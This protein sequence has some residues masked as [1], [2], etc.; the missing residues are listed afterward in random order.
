MKSYSTLYHERLAD[1][2]LHLTPD[3]EVDIKKPW[4][5]NDPEH[6]RRWVLTMANRNGINKKIFTSVLNDSHVKVRRV[7]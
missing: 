7:A 2:I 6:A 4:P 1:Q 3:G 5:F